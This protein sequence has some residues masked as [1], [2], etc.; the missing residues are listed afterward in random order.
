MA[1]TE[2]MLDYIGDQMDKLD[3][4]GDLN[5]NWDKEAHAIE[6]EYTITVVT[7]KDYEIE[8]QE[9]ETADEGSVSYDD[10]VLF[11]DQ[12]RM[13]GADYADSYLTVIPYNGKKG[14]DQATVDGFFDYFQQA[15]DDGESD[16]L[17][18]VDGTSS[19]DEFSVTFEAEKLSSAIDEQPDYKQKVFLPYPKY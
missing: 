1:T 9:G 2:N 15:L 13:K 16:L 3:F 14:I 18:F 4:D 7:N 19:D 10:A 8:D 11:Y 5:L 12:T 6:L 17:D